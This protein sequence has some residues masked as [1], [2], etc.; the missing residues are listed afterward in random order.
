[1]AIIDTADRI[2]ETL[3]AQDTPRSVID[4]VREFREAGRAIDDAQYQ[5]GR[6]AELKAV[7]H[8][9]TVEAGGRQLVDLEAD[10]GK[11]VA[12]E[13]ELHDRTSHERAVQRN[14]H[15]V[16]EQRLDAAQTFA[17]LRLVME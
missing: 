6:A 14:G 17:E 1:M 3:G 8:A 11:T 13:L 5:P 9:K 10:A 16:D 12:V 7:L 4:K 2:L 15:G